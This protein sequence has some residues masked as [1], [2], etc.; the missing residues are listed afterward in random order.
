VNDQLW[1]GQVLA[2]FRQHLTA[3]RGLAAN[4]VRAY[5]A[6]ASTCLAAVAPDGPDQLRAVKLE[7]LRAWLATLAEDGLARASLARRVASVRTFFAWLQHIELIDHDPASRLLVKAPTQGLPQ[8]LSR[9]QAA[10]MLTLAA[11]AAAAGEP[12]P[13]RDWALAELAY[14]TGLRVAELV[15][16][17]IG[18]VDLSN[19][20]VRAMGKGSKPRVVP[21]GQPAARALED[22]LM[23]G[24]GQVLSAVERP[25]AGA[26]VFVGVRGGRLDAREA[27]RIVYRLAA[28]A[29]LGE[30]SPHVLRHS[31][32]THL[33]E[34]GS[35]LRSVQ[36]LLG[37]A[38]L[39]TTQRYTHVTTDRLWDSYAQAHP[40]SGQID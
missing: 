28:A 17:D 18:D 22:W 26:A 33:L 35:D 34:G 21:F 25:T 6:D 11:G 8:V 36:E 19:R 23:A 20:L 3:G 29:N 32:A 9:D 31:A 38:S 40:R 1:P 7:D 39:G 13:V 37:H 12:A 14:A 30:V 15:R 4:T 24:R 16:L 5:L 27:R 10:V 2:D